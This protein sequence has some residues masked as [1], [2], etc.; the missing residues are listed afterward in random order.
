MHEPGKKV[1]TVRQKG[2]NLLLLTNPYYKKGPSTAESAQR[3]NRTSS[4][5]TGDGKRR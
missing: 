5:K 1:S 4:K 2:G 3:G